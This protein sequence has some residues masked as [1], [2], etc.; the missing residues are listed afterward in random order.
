MLFLNANF[1]NWQQMIAFAIYCIPIIMDEKK[2]AF[3][4]RKMKLL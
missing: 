3:L 4:S 1:A 2:M